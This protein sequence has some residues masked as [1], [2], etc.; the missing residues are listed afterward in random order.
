MLMK[1]SH[2]LRTLVASCSALFFACPIPATAADCTALL[3]QHL[4]TDLALPFAEFDQKD[5]AGWRSLSA[6]ACDAEAAVLIEQYVAA[7]ERP[8][9]VLAWHRAQM[10]ARAGNAVQA[11]EVARL[12]LRPPE[13]EAQ[14]EFQWNAYVDATIAFLQADR[15]SLQLQRERL[16]VAAAKFPVNR[17][18]L[19]SVD[20][21]QSCFGKPYKEAYSCGK[22][23]Q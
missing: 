17:P 6:A 23:R 5:G 15:A 7:Q 14:A 13:S 2:P 3:Q 11:I 1:I 18:N 22:P 10:L 20:R 12:T 21:L 8:H 4:Q 19:V 9:P 16:A